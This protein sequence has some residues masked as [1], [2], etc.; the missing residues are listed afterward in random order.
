MI[1]KTVEGRECQPLDRRFLHEKQNGLL[2]RL[3]TYNHRV[4][5]RE[6]RYRYNKTPQGAERL[7]CD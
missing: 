3:K 2:S 7:S 4:A 5:S 1:K 6:N